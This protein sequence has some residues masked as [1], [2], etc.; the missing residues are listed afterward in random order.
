ME[1]RPF[2]F[3]Q[4]GSEAILSEIV[5]KPE[6]IGNVYWF[7][8]SRNEAK[9]KTEKASLDGLERQTEIS[10]KIQTYLTEEQL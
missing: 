4:N 7:Y 9:K 2:C 5:R 3:L 8:S 1:S 10:V 6:G